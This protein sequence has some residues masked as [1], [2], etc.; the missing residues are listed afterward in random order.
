M[1]EQAV[2]LVFVHDGFHVGTQ[3]FRVV[4]TPVEPNHEE[5]A[6]AGAEFFHHLFAQSLVPCLTVAGKLAFALRLEVVDAQQGVPAD[7]DV[8]ARLQAVLAAG[9]HEVAHDV[10]FS[11]AP[12]HGLQAVGVHVAL[13]QSEAR[14]VGGGQD[15]KLG[16]GR[17]GRLNPLVGVE[18][19][20]MEDVVVFNRVDTVVALSVHLSVEHV[21]VVVEYHAQF[22]LVP[23]HLAGS[24]FRSFG[25]GVSGMNGCT[26]GGE[27]HQ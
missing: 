11:V 27:Q 17:L 8:D 5:V 6:V 1:I 10:A 15:G 23:F 25:F 4:G 26:A 14:L 12:F 16:A 24:R 3:A 19:V 2:G 7:A 21:Q 18:V 22:G 13:P 20:G 9:V